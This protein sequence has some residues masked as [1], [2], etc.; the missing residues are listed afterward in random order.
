MTVLHGLAYLPLVLLP[1]MQDAHLKLVAVLN[2]LL[3]LCLIV[4]NWLF[5]YLGI[6]KVRQVLFNSSRAAPRINLCPCWDVCM[7]WFCAQHGADSFAVGVGA[8]LAAA[9]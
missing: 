2:T 9:Q 8:Q 3:C 1:A 4:G 7:L 5:H 6:V